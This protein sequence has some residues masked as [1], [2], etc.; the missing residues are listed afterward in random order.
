MVQWRGSRF[1]PPG[2]VRAGCSR[3]EHARLVA[4]AGRGHGKRKYRHPEEMHFRPTLPMFGW[5]ASAIGALTQS[6]SF[7]LYATRERSVS[8]EGEM[9]TDFFFMRHRFE[10]CSLSSPRV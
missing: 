4:I 9:P 6:K 5:F 7:P 10:Y 1:E 2:E 8:A 3:Y